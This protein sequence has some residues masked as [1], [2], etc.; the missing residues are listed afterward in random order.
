MAA[1]TASNG[2][3][4]YF[5]QYSDTEI[6]FCI[7]KITNI[8]SGKTY[9][10][11]TKGEVLKRWKSHCVP[12][13]PAKTGVG[14]AIKKYGKEFFKFE[15][16][17][18]AETPEQL[19]HMEKFWIDKLDC[20]A[21]NG[22]NLEKGGNSKKLVSALT[23]SRQ[24][25]ARQKWLN[26]SPNLKSLGNGSRG[27]K[28]RPSE[29]DAIIKGLTGRPVSTETREKISSA[30]KG[31][32]KDPEFVLNMARSMMKNKLLLRSDGEVFKS[33]FEAAKATGVSASAIH[34]AA[35][36]KTKTSGGFS[37]QLSAGGI[38]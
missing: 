37:W 33:Y 7:Y 6:S 27:R 4:N 16:I 35:N 23:R 26:G 5:D 32:T 24:K 19:D 20:L 3:L 30:Q 31:V 10:G 14:G 1:F 25:I 22:Y 36:G 11:Q 13:N 12:S 17:G 2:T 18:V 38:I 34:N 8:E 28:R 15:V 21:P 9:V 29:I